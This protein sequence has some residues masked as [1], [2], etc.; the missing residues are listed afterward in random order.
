VAAAREKIKIYRRNGHYVAF[1]PD[2]IKFTPH[3]DA[4]AIVNSMDFNTTL[5]DEQTGRYRSYHTTHRKQPG[6][7]EARRC[8]WLS[9]ST[10]GVSFG[11][12]KL[13]L[14]PDETDDELAKALG[15][16]RA[17]FYG[18]HAWPYEG[19]YLGFVWVFTV[20]KGNAKFG[21]GWDDGRNEPQLI[22]S[23]DGVQWR[24]LPVREP[25]IPHGP[26]G[27]FESGSIYSSGDHP[28]V[29][30]DEVRFYYFG[31]NY[32][33][34]CEEPINSPKLTSGVG[35]ATLGRDRYVAWQAG[36][37]PG[38][39]LTKPLRFAGR[40]LHLNLEA[41]GGEARVALLGA[42]GKPIPGFAAEDCE[43]ISADSFDHVVKWRDSG[44]LSALAG[45]AVRIQFSLKQ[46]SLYTWQFR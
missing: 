34:G 30:G 7:S 36:T 45:K 12:S 27:S 11:E 6:W 19:F 35:L 2:G 32:T 16:R 33:H 46:G 9:E 23:A 5:F 18:M 26:E 21:R 10:D 42:D 22:Y 25:F 43:P 28:V 44:D 3:L 29:I 1:S 20:T 14:A 13:V 15:G 39:L 8:L 38:T 4:P 37:E 31:V 41:K 24:R 40:E 17:E